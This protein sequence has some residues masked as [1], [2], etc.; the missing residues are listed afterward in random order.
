MASR[1]W[2][3]SARYY[4]R[5]KFKFVPDGSQFIASLNKILTN[6]DDECQARIDRNSLHHMIVRIVNSGLNNF[7]E[8]FVCTHKTF[9]EGSDLYGFKIVL[10][11]NE[12]E[13]TIHLNID[14]SNDNLNEL[15]KKQMEK[16]FYLKVGMKIVPSK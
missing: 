13:N 9:T 14:G 16:L 15:I 1:F 8:E 7:N 6:W 11:K 2:R 4:K 3:I 12:S 10:S 5:N